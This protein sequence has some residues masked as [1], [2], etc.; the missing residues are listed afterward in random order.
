MP[1]P[2][3]IFKPSSKAQSFAS[4]AIPCHFFIAKPLTH[5][6][7]WF[8]RMPPRLLFLEFFIAHPSILSLKVFIVR[9]FHFFKKVNKEFVCGGLEFLRKKYSDAH[10]LAKIE[11]EIGLKG[12]SPKMDSFLDFQMTKGSRGR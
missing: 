5:L 4:R 3:A 6:P 12:L 11:E 8:P 1:K 9:G 2:M 10:P 7:S